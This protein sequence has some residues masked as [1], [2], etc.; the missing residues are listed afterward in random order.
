MKYFIALLLV[1]LCIKA[2]AQSVAP[3]TTNNGGLAGVANNIHFEFSLGESFVSTIGNNTLI[4]QGM[5]QPINMAQGPLPVTGLQFT[6][7]RINDDKVQLNWKTIQEMNNAGFHIERRTEN[8]NVFVAVNFVKSKAP[9]GNSTL[10]MQYE[11]V[12]LNNFKGVSYYRLKQT[13][14]DGNFT[15]SVIST[16]KGNAGKSIALKA[17]PIPSR[18]DFSVVVEGIDRETLQLFDA[19]GKLV[20]Q[21]PVTNGTQQKING[22]SPGTYIIRLAGQK[23]LSQVVL[24]Q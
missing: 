13:D 11:A 23:G 24:V 16:V 5:L 3:A 20:R 7:R 21:M 14:T 18:G 8:E 9:N 22:L 2:K 17:W 19:T 10:P 6:A 12:D 15:Y 1:A 4:T